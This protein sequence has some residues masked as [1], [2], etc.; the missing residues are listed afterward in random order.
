MLKSFKSIVKYLL[1]I[2]VNLFFLI[3]NIILISFNVF[4]ILRA[5]L[6]IVQNKRIGFGNIFTSIDLSRKIYKNKKILFILFFDKSRFHNKLIYEILNEKK[7]ILYSSL[8]IKFRKLRL[9]EYD[10]YSNEKR[11]EENSNYSKENRFQNIILYLIKKISRNSCEVIN[12]NKLYKISFDKFF[13]KK[14]NNIFQEF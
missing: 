10:N 9:G 6:I 8:Y 4:K 2:V 5:E 12:I 1:N 11:L 13:K 14:K 7:I 3:L